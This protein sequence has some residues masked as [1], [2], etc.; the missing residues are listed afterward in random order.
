MLSDNLSP[1]T[2]RPIFSHALTLK[3]ETLKLEAFIQNYS[4]GQTLPGKVVQV[5][6]E[7]KA[8]VEIQGEK[9][10]L[11]FS[12]PVTPGQNIAIKIEQTHPNLVLKLTDFSSL[13]ASQ[14]TVSD[15]RA[16]EIPS[17]NIQT[18][19]MGSLYPRRSLCW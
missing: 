18:S 17:V 9:I 2:L 1:N 4:A 12:R 19:D 11:Q 16:K 10:L 14:K 15:H 3:L 8:V 6:P 7:Q 13:N 5:L